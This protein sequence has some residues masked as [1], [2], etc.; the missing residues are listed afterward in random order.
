MNVLHDLQLIFR[1]NLT[2]TRRNPAWTIIALMQ[3]LLYLLLYAPLLDGLNI[4]GFSTEGNS[5]NGFIPGLMVAIA[6]FSLGFAGS[7]VL[8][9][10]QDG[11]IER[12]RVTPA[13]RLGLLLGMILPNVLIFL[14]ECALLVGA[15]ILLGMDADPAGLL[16]LFGLL[17]LVGL[18][19]ASFSYG[20][21]FIFKDQ[22]A[23]AGMISALTLPLLLLSGVLLP[24]TLAPPL[25][26]TLA[27]INPFSHVVE[28]ARLLMAGTLTD[29]AIPLAF[30]IV[31]G[32]AV[33]ML[34]WTVSIFRKATA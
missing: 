23:L 33:V 27:D 14:M 24:L 3:P 30:A 8:P 32:L 7:D 31:G 4:P 15:A 11:V 5:L 1:R 28:A 22:G 20:I 29:S 26:K 18:M 17:A 9:D 34:Y 13:S 2:R 16:I 6:L 12:M 25:M 19:V 10:L 21:A